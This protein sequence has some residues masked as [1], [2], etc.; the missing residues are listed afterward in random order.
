MQIKFK[1]IKID[2]AAFKK[3]VDKEIARSSSAEKGVFKI[4]EKLAQTAKDEMLETFE[5]SPITREINAGAE[6]TINFSK[7]L[8]GIGYG[9]GSLFG[10]IGFDASDD[11]IMMLRDYLNASGKIFK[12]PKITKSG[13]KIN[14]KYR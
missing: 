5:E 13:G 12:T 1:A 2:T 3:N 11:P 7:N 14:Y 10:F 8:M 9:E 4:A 6:N